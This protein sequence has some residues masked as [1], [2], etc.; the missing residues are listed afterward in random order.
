[1]KA[2]A[3][4]DYVVRPRLRVHAPERGDIRGSVRMRPIKICGK[5]SLKPF[6]QHP[7]LSAGEYMGLTR[8]VL[9]LCLGLVL[10][11]AIWPLRAAEVTV[12]A[13]ASLTDSL[14]EI[15]RNY[16]TNSAAKLTSQA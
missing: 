7:T 16:E 13:A 9:L 12:F 15:A 4:R 11:T 10:L 5:M 8:R 2:R 14:K 3:G 6:G 1:M